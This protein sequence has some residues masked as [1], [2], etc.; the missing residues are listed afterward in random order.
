MRMRGLVLLLASLGCRSTE[1]SPPESPPAPDV[2][3]VAA[4]LPVTRDPLACAKATP[5]PPRAPEELPGLHNAFRLSANVISGAEPHGDEGLDTLARLGVR[6]IISV[7]G[8][9]PDGD[10]AARCGM[11]YVHIP[12]QYS[13]ITEDEVLR[14][15]K[16]YRELPGPFYIHCFHGKHRGPPA[17]MVGRMILDGASRAQVLAE[18]AQWC[19]TAAKYRGMY[20]DI[21]RKP[22]PSAE[23][24]AAYAF[25]FPAE[26][27]FKGLRGTMVAA[28]RAYDPLAGL[29][30]RG[31]AVDP[32]H[33]DIDPVNQTQQL[34][35]YLA[36]MAD[37]PETA[38]RPQDFRGWAAESVSASRDLHDALAAGDRARADRA[39][40]TV[41]SRCDA[42]HKVYRD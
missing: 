1:A 12:M 38:Q 37:L 21:A 5:L 8:K 14:L 23:I 32:E 27:R 22:V 34:A 18:M 7:D 2:P 39:Y 16:T 26:H 40:Q 35:A 6:T 15:A 33:P 29:Q 11:R 42:C 30:K 19:E 24:T 10:G 28:S 41:K 25:D 20:R 31:W 3:A 17:A 9:A 13:G 4:P 36:Q